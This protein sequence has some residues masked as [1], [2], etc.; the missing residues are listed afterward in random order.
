MTLVRA[1]RHAASVAAV[2][3][4]SIKWEKKQLHKILPK[5]RD[6]KCTSLQRC[7]CGKAISQKRFVMLHIECRVAVLPNA[8]ATRGLPSQPTVSFPPCSPALRS[9]SKVANVHVVVSASMK[10]S[11][12]RSLLSPSPLGEGKGSDPF[13][14]GQRQ[15]QHPPKVVTTAREGEA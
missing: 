6:A 8:S 9:S 12:A 4:I 1:R 10:S 5:Q 3:T 13:P 11:A 14:P 15:Q 7:H 2:P